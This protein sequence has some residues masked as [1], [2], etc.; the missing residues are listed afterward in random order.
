MDH[1]EII[2]NELKKYDFV[3]NEIK[4]LTE[5]R[6]KDGILYRFSY[7]V[8]KCVIK[9]FEQEAFRREIFYYQLLGKLQIPTIKLYDST[10]TSIILEDINNSNQYRLG[11]KEDLSNP[12]IALG[13]INWYQKFHHQ[14]SIYLN[15]HPELLNQLFNEYELITKDVVLDLINKTDSKVYGYWESF[16]I[17]FDKIKSIINNQTNCLTYNDFY[18]TNFI[19]SNDE[20]EVIMYD[21]NLLGKGF[22]YSDI[23]NVSQ[24]LQGKAKEVFLNHY[25][26]YDQVEKEIDDVFSTLYGLYDAYKKDIFPN[27]AVEELNHIHNGNLEK[28]IIKLLDTIKNSH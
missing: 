15:E 19:V 3:H 27:W 16:L 4:D 9:Y 7:Q 26:E 17:E 8:L 13:L 5:I 6:V 18:Y 24:S 10:D 11:I 12:K 28:N 2:L 1:Q 23:R 22:K 20:E 25:I 14:S 21:Y